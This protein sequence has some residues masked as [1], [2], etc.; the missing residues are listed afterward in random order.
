MKFV[1]VIVLFFSKEWSDEPKQKCVKGRIQTP[2]VC[3]D[4]NSSTACIC[5]N[6]QHNATNSCIERIV[7]A[8]TEF[9]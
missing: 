1:I 2:P 8:P 9:L 5:N 6:T 7:Y 4:G 3:V